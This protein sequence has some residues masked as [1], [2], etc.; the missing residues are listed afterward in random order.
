MDDIKGSW[1]ELDSLFRGGQI[2]Q[3]DFVDNAQML[4]D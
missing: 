2:T 3:K 4:F 1:E